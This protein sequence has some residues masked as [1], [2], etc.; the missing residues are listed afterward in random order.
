MIY[1]T[2]LREL[3]YPSLTDCQQSYL[4]FNVFEYRKKTAH[5]R[6]N[7]IS[8][9]LIYNTTGYYSVAHGRFIF[10]TRNRLKFISFIFV[11]VIHIMGIAVHYFFMYFLV[12]LTACERGKRCN[13]RI[14]LRTAAR[15]PFPGGLRDP[16]RPPGNPHVAAPP[17]KM[18]LQMQDPRLLRYGQYNCSVRRVSPFKCC[19]RSK[20]NAKR[21]LPSL[22]RSGAANF[23]ILRRSPEDASEH[24]STNRIY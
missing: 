18:A 24:S 11:C 1:G 4:L 14:E 23:A 15:G 2:A 16:R 20:W 6:T 19:R 17:Q 21:F 13:R 8:I 7:N 3:P 22:Y 12:V 10:R 5:P 9:Y